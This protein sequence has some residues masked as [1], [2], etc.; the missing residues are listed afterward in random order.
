MDSI[1]CASY[2][3]CR[4]VCTSIGTFTDGVEKFLHELVIRVSAD[5]EVGGANVSEPW[6]K[7]R[8]TKCE[9]AVIHNRRITCHRD[10]QLVRDFA[11]GVVRRSSIHG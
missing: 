5:E 4:I 7:S 2:S 11:S 9:H 10:F 6:C 3:T 8:C 1:S